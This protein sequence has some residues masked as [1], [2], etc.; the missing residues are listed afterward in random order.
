MRK[1]TLKFQVVIGIIT[2]V[3]YAASYIPPNFFWPAGFLSYCIPFLMLLNLLFVVI[4]IL[5]KWQY[6][7]I[8]LFII[9][10]G[11]KS[12][13]ATV[14]YNSPQSQTHHLKLVSY[15]V[16]CFNKPNDFAE[17][18]RY[19]FN[20]MISLVTSNDPDIICFQEYCAYHNYPVFD[21]KY[22]LNNIKYNYQVFPEK[23]VMHQ[24]QNDNLAIYSKRPIFNK[25]TIRDKDH[26]L[27]A[28]FADVV[29]NNDTIRIYNV[30][31]QSMG[32]QFD[33]DQGFFFK[34]SYLLSSLNNGFIKRSS[35][36]Q[37]LM[38]HVDLSEHHA[39]I[40]GDFNELPYGYVY[41]RLSKSHQNSFEKKG[42]GFGFTFSGALKYLKIDHQF[43]AP[44]INIVDHQVL[45][46]FPVSDHH[47]IEVDYNINQSP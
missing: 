36:I 45:D 41:K 24:I 10:I 2:L 47:P 4:W 35:Q 28:L 37:E 20:D 29:L 34:A 23:P 16:N 31:L 30:H 13:K 9:L 15:N 43:A 44:D 40:C 6:M 42:T 7:L 38:S 5:L 8:P 3:S 19:S 32:L 25:G 18:D 17:K 39:I 46:D 12:I 26:Q 1:H 22:R 14:G 11:I 21:A 33:N 27:I